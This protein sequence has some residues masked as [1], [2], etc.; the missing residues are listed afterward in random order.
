MQGGRE[1]YLT[2]PAQASMRQPWRRPRR[3]SLE[4]SPG[5]GC[6][7]AP[8]PAASSALR[9]P[10]TAARPPP[11]NRAGK[12]A[13]DAPEQAHIAGSTIVPDGKQTDCACL[14]RGR[15]HLGHPVEGGVARVREQVCCALQ[16]GG[17]GGQQPPDG[18]QVALQR[19]EASLLLL[20]T[21][22][23]PF[24]QGLPFAW[25]CRTD[26][27][28]MEAGHEKTSI[29]GSSAESAFLSITADLT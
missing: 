22:A 24:N 10:K 13:P 28:T 7:P 9:K 2:A 21:C 5:P 19:P 23:S 16:D 17:A 8:R 1:A 27:K 18:V 15:V 6:A 12:V 4:Q 14:G 25:D 20:S 26:R 29:Y 3:Q 11:A